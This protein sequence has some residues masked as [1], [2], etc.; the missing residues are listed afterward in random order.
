MG[1]QGPKADARDSSNTRDIISFSCV[2]L[3]MATRSTWIHL[4]C[5]T[6]MNLHEIGEDSQSKIA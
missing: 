4:S 1:K 3:P 5:S 2:L 6:G